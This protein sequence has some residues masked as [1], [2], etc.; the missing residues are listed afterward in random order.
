MKIVFNAIYIYYNS[1]FFVLS[2]DQKLE[3]EFIY[4]LIRFIDNYDKFSTNFVLLLL[5]CI[6]T[7]FII[8]FLNSESRF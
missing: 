6:L 2:F 4:A 1:V 7:K 3:L 5:N 8:D